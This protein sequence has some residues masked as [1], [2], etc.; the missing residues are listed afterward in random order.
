MT[1]SGRFWCELIIGSAA[2]VGLAYLGDCIRDAPCTPIDGSEFFIAVTG[3]VLFLLVL[4]SVE[5]ARQASSGPPPH[6]R[7]KLRDD[8]E[9]AGRDDRDDGGDDGG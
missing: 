5:N 8:I 7:R 9:Q 1:Y 2:L 4:A 6:R 3:V